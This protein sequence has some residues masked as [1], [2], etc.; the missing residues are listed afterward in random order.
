MAEVC[1]QCGAPPKHAQKLALLLERLKPSLGP[2]VIRLLTTNDVPI[3]SEIPVVQELLSDGEEVLHALD[4]QILDL[5]NALAQLAQKRIKAVNHLRECRAILSPVRRIPQEL[6]CE[7]FDLSTVRERPSRVRPWERSPWRLGFI[8]RPWRQYALGYAP[9]WSFFA[10]PAHALEETQINRVLADLET[11]LLRCATAPLDILWSKVGRD[12]PD[13]RILDLVLPHSD[14]WRTVSFVDYCSEPMLDWLEPVRG[15]LD[16]LRR[17]EAVDV[18][19]AFSGVFMSAPNL[20][21]V[22]LRQSSWLDLFPEADQASFPIPWAQ[23]THYQG[24]FSFAQQID[25]LLAAPNLSHCSL[26]IEEWDHD[27]IPPAHTTVTLP[28]LRRLCLDPIG[29]L[30]HIVAPQL[31]DLTC[32]KQGKEVVS[33]IPPFVHRASCTLQKLALWRCE[34]SSELIAALRS[35]PSLTSLLLEDLHHQEDD[36][37][38]FFAAMSISDT[39]SD[40][41]PSLTFMAYGYEYW[42][43]GASQDSFVHMAQSRFHANSNRPSGT[44]FGSLRLF[45]STD[46]QHYRRPDPEIMARIRSLQHEGFNVAFLDEDETTEY[47]RR[48]CA[49]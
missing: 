21:K 20:C 33:R 2:D 44:H 3:D 11:R 7:I 18:D 43:S 30:L 10:V 35:L 14:R 6:V 37:V 1:W 25:I 40:V 47:L 27:F 31:E 5:Q 29:C 46:L 38:D 32:S 16:R 49:V 26:D 28:H 19:S 39:T 45:C 34:L 13:S 4:A 9:L 22:V 8:S 48:R 41:C 36:G 42:A 24:K 12:S 15:K 17:L 23:I